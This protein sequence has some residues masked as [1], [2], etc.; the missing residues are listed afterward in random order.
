MSSGRPASGLGLA[1]DT[2][3]WAVFP[4]PTLRL[5]PLLASALRPGDPH[6]LQLPERGASPAGLLPIG[7][8]PG[9]A[10]YPQGPKSG[11]FRPWSNGGAPESKERFLSPS[12]GST[13]DS[14]QA[15]HPGP[16]EPW[17][18]PAA[19]RSEGSVSDPYLGALLGGSCPW[20]LG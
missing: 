7:R 4:C 14:A 6:R 3:G 10:P 16:R 11:H 20:W 2:A 15:S 9:P 12:V 13:E 18:R 8:I 19:A 5:A 17:D 1:I